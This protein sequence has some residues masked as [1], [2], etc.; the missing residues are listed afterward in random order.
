MNSAERTHRIISRVRR[1]EIIFAIRRRERDTDAITQAPNPSGDLGM[2]SIWD[3][4]N[5]AK[6]EKGTTGGE[7][8]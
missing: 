3:W 8:I 7:V 5:G 6:I 2:D 4:K 1:R